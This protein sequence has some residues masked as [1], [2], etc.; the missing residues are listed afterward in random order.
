MHVHSSSG[1]R[2]WTWL[3]D[4][5][6][7]PKTLAWCHTTDAY[8]LRDI[9]SAGEF[10][11]EP[12]AVFSEDLIYFFYGRPAYRKQSDSSFHVSGRAPVIVVLEPSL[13]TLGKR[14]FPFDTGAFASNRYSTWMHASM[15]L[16]DFGLDC[17]SDAPQRHV[18]SF[19]GTNEKY[20]RQQAKIPEVAYK[21]EFEVE[22]LVALLTDRNIKLA[23]DRRTALELQTDQVVPFAHPTVR[24]LVVPDELLDAPFLKN[25]LSSTGSRI[26]VR[27]Y[28]LSPLKLSTDYQ[29]LLEER[30]ADLQEHWGLV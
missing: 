11:P 23:D 16:V 30:A 13:V 9:I 7:F 21:G 6:P 18:T 3:K 14:M 10:C 28:S 17:P 12:C 2:F 1:S 29:A 19:F 4:V 22:C 20:L 26:D 8:A 25:F 15:R 27:P 24:G 5:E